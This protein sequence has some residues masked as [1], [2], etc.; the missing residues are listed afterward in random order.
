VPPPVDFAAE[1]E[2]VEPVAVVDGGGRGLA[3]I[4]TVRRGADTETTLRGEGLVRYSTLDLDGPPRFVV[5]L[6]GVTAAPLN[7]AVDTPLVR[8]IR[9]AAFRVGVA[10]VVFDLKAP[11]A[12]RVE[13]EGDAVRVI[14]RPVIAS[15]SG[16]GR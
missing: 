3:R 8:G 12:A 11:V 2:P 6:I 10:R 15:A 9:V 1:T 5:D 13:R 16:A 7:V 4:E 14:L